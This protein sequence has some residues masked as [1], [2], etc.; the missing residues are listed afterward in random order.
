MADVG[1]VGVGPLRKTDLHT[2]SISLQNSFCESHTWRLVRLKALRE[3]N[4]PL[5]AACLFRFRGR[6]FKWVRRKFGQ[7]KNRTKQTNMT[8]II[9]TN[10]V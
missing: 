4:T 6:K 2:T 10:F 1:G 7:A 3:H 9:A 8:K 5:G